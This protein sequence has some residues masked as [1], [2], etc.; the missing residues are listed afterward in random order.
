MDAVALLLPSGDRWT[1][2]CGQAGAK[3]PGDVVVRAFERPVLCATG[4]VERG[5]DSEPILIPAG[6]GRRV[7]GFHVFARPADPSAA[8]RISYRGV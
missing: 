7:V 3:Q 8:S 4:E 6:Q 5:P 1:Y 2:V